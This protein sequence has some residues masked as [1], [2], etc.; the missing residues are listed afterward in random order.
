[1]MPLLAY[2]AIFLRRRSID[3]RQRSHD[4]MTHGDGMATSDPLNTIVPKKKKDQ[5]NTRNGVRT[6][7]CIRTLEL[8]SNA[9]TTR[10]SW[11]NYLTKGLRLKEANALS[12][13]HLV[14]VVVAFLEKATR[15]S[16]I[17]K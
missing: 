7:V 3:R 16:S 15:N 8:K 5:N 6:H 4:S 13:S 1:M 12:L 2:S 11:F 9:L 17:Q 14:L 10:P